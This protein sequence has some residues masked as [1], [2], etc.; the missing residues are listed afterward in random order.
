MGKNLIWPGLGAL[1]VL[2]GALSSCSGNTAPPVQPPDDQTPQTPAAPH[3]SSVTGAGTSL[4]TVAATDAN[5]DDITVTA[6][7]PSGFTV[8][9]DTQVILDGDGTATFSFTPG[10]VFDGGS[11]S[12][13]FVAT[14]GLTTPEVVKTVEVLSPPLDFADNTLYAIPMQTEAAVD[15]PVTILVATGKLP[16]PL[17]FMTGVRVCAPEA[18]DYVSDSFNVG[19]LGGAKDFKDGAWAALPAG[20][21]FLLMPDVF[22]KD[23]N[24]PSGNGQLHEGLRC[25]D[26]NITPIETVAGN[27]DLSQFAIE[28]AKGELFNFQVAFHSPGVYDVS[29]MLH[30]GVDRTYYMERQPVG[31]ETGL[32]LYWGEISNDYSGVPHTVTVH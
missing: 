8:T 11:G 27:H 15:E 30:Q 32:E 1:A 2:L 26:F 4:I 28:E 12:A 16:N 14:D 6:T 23:P 20:H 19:A 17:M 10:D 5:G 13:G 3:I 31:D 21:S 29:F 9:P 24:S 22:I 25:Y 18:W 7:A